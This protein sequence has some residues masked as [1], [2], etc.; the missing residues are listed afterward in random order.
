MFMQVSD[1]TSA[2]IDGIKKTG[3]KTVQFHEPVG[4]K[5]KKK[6]VGKKILSGDEH[7][8]LFITHNCYILTGSVRTMFIQVQET[9]NPNSMKFVPGVQVLEH[10]TVNFAS[11]QS[12]Y[13]SPLAR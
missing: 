11:A 12:A 10:G 2:L 13:P 9:P 6:P 1:L 7:D 3:I 5:E 4:K 8:G